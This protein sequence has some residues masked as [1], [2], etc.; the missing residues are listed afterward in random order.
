MIVG[1]PISTLARPSHV[2]VS[3]GHP[4]V[5]APY[6]FIVR[7]NVT[8]EHET[9]FNAWYDEEHVHDVARLPGCLRGSRYRVLDGI[10]GDVSYRY[11]MLYEFESEQALREATQSPY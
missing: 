4:V 5:A 7:A 2:F 3:G 1:A 11:L 10:E 9:A 8:P 6:L